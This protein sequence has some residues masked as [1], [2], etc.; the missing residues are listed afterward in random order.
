MYQIHP[1]TNKVLL[2]ITLIAIGFASYGQ[3]PS[4]LN[5]QAIARNT[6]GYSLPNQAM[7]IRISIIDN[8][9][10]GNLLYSEI[11]AVKTNL[12]GLFSLIIG[13]TGAISYKGNIGNI[14]WASGD[15]YLHVEIDPTVENGRNVG[16]DPTAI[17][18]FL[19]MGIVKLVSVPYALL[20]SSAVSA[21]TVTT[22][23][24]LTGAVTSLGNFTSIAPSPNLEG[25]PTAP[26]ADLETSTTQ[27]AT[28]EFVHAA[29]TKHLVGFTGQIGA[30][31]L[32]GLTGA[33]GATGI[34]G[35]TGA[36]G[37]KGADGARGIQGLTGAK[38]LTGATGVKGADGARGIQGLTG[39]TGVKG[40]DGARGIQGLTG[41]QGIDGVNGIQGLT[42]ATGLTGSNGV[43]GIDGVTGIQGLTG[44]TGASGVKGDDGPTGIQGLTGATGLTGSTG[45]QGVDGVTGIQG[46]T[47]L[48]GASGVKGDDGA[49][50]IQGLTGAT[51][52]TGSNGVQGIDGATGIQGLTG[53]TGLTGSNGVQG[54]DGVTGIQ[55]LTGA[56]GLT[57]SNGEQGIDG[58]TGTQ[59]LTGA[60]GLTGSNGVQGNVGVTGL[61]GLTGLTG[62]SGVKGDDG[63]TGIQGLIGAT[64]LT[65]SN[66]VK[67]IDGVT[68]IQGLTGLTGASGVKGDDGATG[69]Q[70][71]AGADF[72]F[73][74]TAGDTSQYWRWDKT[75]QTINSTV[76]GLGNVN[77]TSDLDKPI[78][79]ATLDY[80]LKNTDRYNVISS[81]SEIST[82][83]SSDV[84]VNGMT[85]TTPN[86]GTYL[87]N[88]NSQYTL[89]PSNRTAQAIAELTAAFNY[90]MA[91]PITNSTHALV[92]GAGETL[93]PGVYYNA[94]AVTAS[95]SITL[96]AGGNPN[97]QFIFQFGAAFSTGTSFNVTLTNGAS[98]CNVFWVA[99]GAI[100]FG[101]S[102][103][104]K[105]FIFSNNGAVTIGSMSN[106]EGNIFSSGGTIGLDEST[107]TRLAGCSNNFGSINNFAVF[108]KSGNISN[109]GATNITGDI[110]T[111]S[112]NI[113][114]FGSA[115]INGSIYP[116]GMSNATASF[117]VYQN[118][119]QI[120]FSSRRRSSSNKLGEISLQAIATV[121]SSENI[122]IRWNIDSGFIKLQNRILTLLS[123][124]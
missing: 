123:V 112:G 16:N 71:L 27:I 46:L 62:T 28:T 111:N 124:R 108:S 39:A 84:I 67:G 50:G 64:G 114:G 117:S 3:A 42:G 68:G 51:G 69:I 43:K 36:T 98:A 63:P 100:A 119:I 110:S 96:D 88:F 15:K 76:V 77:N 103:I 91:K 115:T 70:G 38:G 4:L 53:A 82:S 57:G 33:I 54:N 45:V 87:V 78:S 101:A 95:G 89:E 80:I 12:V 35:L 66:G 83:S 74:I 73:P 2:F 23:A 75:W 8:S 13:S 9:P 116:S 58:A 44:L 61:Q 47:G 34:Q 55:G 26:T 37:I 90:L 92:Y 7:N 24:N 20:A 56:T 5:Y 106:V 105:G 52:L 102:T 97:A 49:T 65:G 32:T 93:T 1:Q 10:S 18:D 19:D 11:R 120:P 29:V 17:N 107:I 30:Q 81:G 109:V 14:N 118:G 6:N 40:A 48:T 21:A 86:P 41:V 25:L 59:G 79:T 94:G 122:D 104:M 113:T 85:L 60:T 72:K 31:G 99:E 22:N 121:G